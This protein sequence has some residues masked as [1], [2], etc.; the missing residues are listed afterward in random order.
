MLKVEVFKFKVV[1]D[2]SLVI[3][4]VLVAKV[5]IDVDEGTDV[6]VV[7]VVVTV[8]DV[9]VVIADVVTVEVVSAYVVN[10]E[11]VSAD[12]VNEDVLE[13]ETGVVDD[14]VVVGVELVVVFIIAMEFGFEI[15]INV[16]FVLWK[17]HNL[18]NLL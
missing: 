8:V 7:C 10:V 16:I 6:V 12:V 11:V 15:A 9:E 17:L 4:D 5:V 14:L 13:V 2:V 3:K 1:V 18:I